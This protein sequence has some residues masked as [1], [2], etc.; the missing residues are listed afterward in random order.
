[1]SFS[2]GFVLSSTKGHDGNKKSTFACH[3]LDYGL[4]FYFHCLDCKSS[5]NEMQEKHLSCCMVI[6]GLHVIMGLPESKRGHGLKEGGN[7]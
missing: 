1:M 3:S 4:L 2:L 6:T 5:L 7:D